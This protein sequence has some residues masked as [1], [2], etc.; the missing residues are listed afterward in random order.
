MKNLNILVSV[1]LDK[2]N[3]FKWGIDYYVK[4][5]DKIKIFYI[6]EGYPFKI[7][8]IFY[9]R[10]IKII[11]IDSLYKIFKLFDIKSNDKLFL[12]HSLSGIKSFII[13]IILYLKKKKRIIFKLG[14][15]PKLKISRKSYLSKINRKIFKIISIRLY[16]YLEKNFL[17]KHN[18]YF[19]AGKKF[20]QEYKNY[21]IIKTHSWDFNDTLN[22]RKN[23]IKKNNY[24]LYLDQYAHG[25]P[26]YNY[27]QLNKIDPK[28][29][30]DSLNRFFNQLEKKFKKKII[31]AAHPKA[32]KNSYMYKKKSYFKGREIYFN[33]TMNLIKNCFATLLHDTTAISYA[34][35]YKKPSIFI[36]NNE[37]IRIK[38]NRE[39]EIRIF[40]KELGSYFINIDNKSCIKNF[41]TS[42]NNINRKKYKK[43][44][45]DYINNKK[46]N[47]NIRIDKIICQLYTKKGQ[48][49]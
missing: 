28:T 29:F 33:S 8:K 5:F 12:D 6:D 38:T 17:F 22:K 20:E 39:N 43:F 3:Y 40:A 27:F 14:N 26:D 35:I 45:I 41:D 7:E 47:K 13:K 36:I 48:L 31:I 49:N 10:K 25:H 9:H 44:L 32:N 2:K 11:K 18:I 23:H 34:V 21:N 15:I 16:N 37:M 42:I 1:H 46:N 30:Y 4:Y 24:F 19:C